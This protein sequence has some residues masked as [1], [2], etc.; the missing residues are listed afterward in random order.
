M[1][2]LEM[3][4]IGGAALLFLSQ[5]K[6]SGPGSATSAANAAPVLAP[7]LVDGYV[8]YEE[9]PPLLPSIDYSP[10]GGSI[11]QGGAEYAFIGGV[12]VRNPSS[13]GFIF[14]AGLGIWR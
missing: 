5:K 14:D 13:T 4:L 3:A 7:V 6:S 1:K 8:G 10:W 2:P 11:A 12:N 9:K